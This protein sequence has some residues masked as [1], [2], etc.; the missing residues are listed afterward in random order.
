[1]KASKV[2]LSRFDGMIEVLEGIAGHRRRGTGYPSDVL[3]YDLVAAYYRRV[4]QAREEGKPV[5]AH[6]IMLPTELFIALDVVPLHLECLATT[7]PPSLR[8]Y[9]ELFA[10]ARGFG[11]PSEICSTHRVMAAL[12]AQG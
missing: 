4:R 8:N 2:D 7:L 3:Y 5:V 1:M 6:S 12:F 11:L 10:A 9:E